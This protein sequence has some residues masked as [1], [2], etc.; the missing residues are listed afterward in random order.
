METYMDFIGG[1]KFF[2]YGTDDPAKIK[3]LRQRIADRPEGVVII[4][5][6]P[7]HGMMVRLPVQ[8]W[9]Y[10]PKPKTKGKKMTDEQRAK[11]VERLAK[12]REAQRSKSLT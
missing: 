4:M 6:D 5:D 11:A 2:T 1:D 12:A 9:S 10:E 8:T 7:E 3:R